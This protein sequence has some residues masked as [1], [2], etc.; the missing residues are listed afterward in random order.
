MHEKNKTLSQL[1]FSTCP[2]T[3]R[4]NLTYHHFKKKKN[5]RITLKKYKTGRWDD[6]E[7]ALFEYAFMKHGNDWK[8]VITFLI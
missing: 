4:T 6:K 5:K 2:E 1:Q 7:H 8:S 3:V